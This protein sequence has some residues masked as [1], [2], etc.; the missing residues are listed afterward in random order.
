MRAGTFFNSAWWFFNLTVS[1]S[2]I[3]EAQVSVTSHASPCI[4][5]PNK[6]LISTFILSTLRAL[7]LNYNKCAPTQCWVLLVSIQHN[8]YKLGLWG[9]LYWI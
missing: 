4:A 7:P 8:E 2:P 5:S 1:L 9:S 3:A 6:E